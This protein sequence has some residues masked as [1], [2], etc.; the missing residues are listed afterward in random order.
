MA[1]PFTNIFDSGHCSRLV[2]WRSG[3]Q[4]TIQHA[5][6]K[7]NGKIQAKKPIQSSSIVTYCLANKQ[8]VHV[9]KKLGYSRQGLGKYH[10]TVWSDNT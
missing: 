8:A 5:Y 9:C 1:R 10:N 3:R 2:A 7:S 4:L 6:T